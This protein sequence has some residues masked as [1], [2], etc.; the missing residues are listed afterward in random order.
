MRK[1]IFIALPILFLGCNNEKSVEDNEP[2]VV[3]K[4]E[5]DK[6]SY[7]LGAMSGQS[8]IG[9]QD[10][11]LKRLDMEELAKGF[12]ENLNTQKPEQCQATLVKLFGPNGQDFDSTYA[13]EGAHCFGRLTSYSFYR[14]IEKMGI[15][16]EL[17][18]SLVKVGFRHALLKKDSIIPDAEKRTII[19]QFV[20]NFNETAGKKMMDQAKQVSGAKVFENGIVMVTLS[21]GKGGNP[22]QT[23]DV[24]VN[25]ILT[26][27]KGDTIESS[28]VQRAPISISLE[29]VIPGWVYAIPKMKKGGKYRIYV[30]W[31]LAYGEQKGRESLCFFVELVDYAKKGTFVKP[32]PQQMGIPG[33]GF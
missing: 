33:Q 12:A 8:I 30:P 17:D 21:E 25:Y 11:N 22:S 15:K 18:F 13:K 26:S 23:D 32:Q 9:G 3:L 7:A 2:P 14:E 6:L 5:K 27:A 10:P 20:I 28:F 19:Q 1:L 29:A 4:T 31:E 24:K 16:N